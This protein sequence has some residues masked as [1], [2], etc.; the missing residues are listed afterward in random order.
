[1]SCPTRYLAAIL[2]VASFALPR[3]CAAQHGPYVG[4]TGGV[5]TLSADSRIVLGPDHVATASYKPENGPTTDVYIGLH[6]NNY[7]SIQADYLWNRNLLTL[8]GLVAGRTNSGSVFFEQAFQ[9]RQYGAVGNALLFFRPRCSWV[10]PFLSVGTG[11]ARLMAEPRSAGI[12]NGISPPGPFSA[13]KPILHVAVGIDLK[14]KSGWG[15]RYSFAETSSANP[16]DQQLT[17]S[18]SHGLA[19]FRNLFGFVKYF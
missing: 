10:R 12:A 4:I 11:F 16:I 13:T 9:S 3:P 17:P 15:F 18:G 2:A 19:N 14:V 8:D 1:M 7:L 5:S 6:W